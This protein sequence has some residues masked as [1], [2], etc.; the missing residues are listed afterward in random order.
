MPRPLKRTNN[1]TNNRTNAPVTSRLPNPPCHVALQ[2]SWEGPFKKVPHNKS[3]TAAPLHARQQLC[4]CA[5]VFHHQRT[6]QYNR[7]APYESK[8]DRQQMPACR[9]LGTCS[10]PH[11]LQH[12]RPSAACRK[13]VCAWHVTNHTSAGVLI[14][15]KTTAT[16]ML[17]HAQAWH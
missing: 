17:A 3:H 1:P 9:A 10:T 6:R 15:E 4:I 7:L 13:A 14:V 12:S 5:E 11:A 16:A 8:H 2:G